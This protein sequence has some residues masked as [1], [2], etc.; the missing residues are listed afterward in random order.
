MVSIARPVAVPDKVR[1]IR[2][3]GIAELKQ[4]VRLRIIEPF[5][6]FP[7]SGFKQLQEGRAA[8]CCSTVR[9]AAARP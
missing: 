6:Q 1:F 3:V 5:V 2:I 8:V 4:V 7:A 9:P